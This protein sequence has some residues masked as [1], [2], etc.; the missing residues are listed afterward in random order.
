MECNGHPICGGSGDLGKGRG[1][2][3][4][5]QCAKGSRIEV[6]VRC[7]YEV[8]STNAEALCRPGNQSRVL[9]SNILENESQP[10]V[11]VGDDAP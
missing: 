11:A 10:A 5:A 3:G 7:V 2:G 1:L 8:Q 9:L 4:G 6:H